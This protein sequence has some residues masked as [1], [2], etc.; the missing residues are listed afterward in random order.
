[1][2]RNNKL[3]AGAMAHNHMNETSYNNYISKL[4]SALDLNNN[5]NA[6]HV[7]EQLKHMTNSELNNKVI[8][9]NNK[10]MAVESLKYNSTQTVT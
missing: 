1:M 3:P 4:T 6:G 10:R 5:P 8:D 9:Y 7:L 2:V